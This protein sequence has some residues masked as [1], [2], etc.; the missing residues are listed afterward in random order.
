MKKTG[1]SLLASALVVTISACGSESKPSASPSGASASPT[2]A[3][4]ASPS[5]AP[6][7]VT[8]KIGLPGS[9]DITKKEIID[10]FKAKF[11]TITLEITD[12]PWADFATKVT[13][14]IAGGNP[15]D[16]WFQENAIV[17][18]YGKRG[19]AE[20]LSP[21]V[22]RDLKADD[23]TANLLAAQSADGKIW[24]IPHGVNPST[25]VYN[26]KLFADAGV[27]FPTKNWTYEDML[28][29]ARK[30]TK[31]TN[32]D[33]KTDIY[34][35]F[36]QSNI[37]SG[38][39]PWSKVA[40][41]GIL[42]ATKTK[43]IVSDPKTIEGLTKWVGTIKEGLSPTQDI[44]KANGGVDQMFGN[45]KIGIMP[46]QYNVTATINKNFPNLDYDAIE[47]PV[48]WDGKRVTPYVVNS[49]V[50]FSKAKQEVKDAAWEFLKYYLSD[51]AQNMIA[52]GG[53]EI[54][55]KKSAMAKIDATTKPQN[56]KA[57][58]DG[59][60]E[61]GMTTDE[62]DSWQEWRLAAQPI[63]ADIYN[64]VVTPEAGAK[65]IQAKIQD[66]LERNK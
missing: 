10:G 14:Q 20:D 55:V 59:V 51:E 21:Y 13:T 64:M 15:P 39:Y 66:V 25:L 9:Y 24:G 60:A 11:P 61:S 53:A 40:G 4:S 57:Y 37:T 12:T 27:P 23:Y 47:M 2:A 54:P 6:K 7:P 17:L 30:L 3:A 43:A 28:G 45:G 33:G 42:D 26:K 50:V 49:W 62:N 38:W 34:G 32:G 18:N 5:A 22:K 35:M 58:T 16:I 63:F 41:G 44:Y 8:L 31:D 65:Q 56:K 48:G 19:V 36:V 52:S 46:V 29:I 1:L